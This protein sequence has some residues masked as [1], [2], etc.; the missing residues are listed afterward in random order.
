MAEHKTRPQ[1]H[2]ADSASGQEG[3]GRQHPTGTGPAYRASTRRGTKGGKPGG[4][5]DRH[6]GPTDEEQD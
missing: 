1:D 6:Q 3:S 5:R 2:Q 4:K